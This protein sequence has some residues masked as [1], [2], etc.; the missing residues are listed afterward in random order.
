MS[1]WKR[2]NGKLHRNISLATTPG[3][4]AA[5]REIFVTA[6]FDAGFRDYYMNRR[7]FYFKRVC[8]NAP[9]FRGCLRDTGQRTIG[10]SA[11]R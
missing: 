5:R 11:G 1:E 3:Q 9:V 10:E 2:S 8:K 6:T 4:G 7:R